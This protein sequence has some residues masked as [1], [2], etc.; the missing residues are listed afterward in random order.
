MYYLALLFWWRRNFAFGGGQDAESR[1]IL[2][3]GC[4]AC[5]QTWRKFTRTMERYFIYAVL[6]SMFLFLRSRF[7]IFMFSVSEE[8]LVIL[9]LDWIGSTFYIL[10]LDWIQNP[11]FSLLL[12]YLPC[13]QKWRTSLV[14]FVGDLSRRKDIL[15]YGRSL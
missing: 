4:T 1:G 9:Y 12:S 15:L 13:A 8:L 2:C 11:H 10:Y 3:V 6:C 5:L 7:W 14:A